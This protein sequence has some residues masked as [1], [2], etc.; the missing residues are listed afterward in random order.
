MLNLVQF[1]CQPSIYIYVRAG[2]QRRESL[3]HRYGSSSGGLSCGGGEVHQVPL[4]SR[5]GVVS[6]VAWA[7][8]A[9]YCSYGKSYCKIVLVIEHNGAKCCRESGVKTEGIYSDLGI[10]WR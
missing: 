8:S 4:E 3:T 10:N 2:S 7:G 9:T 5:G 6:C 1:P